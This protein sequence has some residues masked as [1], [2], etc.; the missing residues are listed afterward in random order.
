M[1]IRRCS[2][3]FAHQQRTPAESAFQGVPKRCCRP[4]FRHP[5]APL[6]HRRVCYRFNTASPSRPLF[7]RLVLTPA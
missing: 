6:S 4:G 2:R 1:Y 7:F 3:S 5:V